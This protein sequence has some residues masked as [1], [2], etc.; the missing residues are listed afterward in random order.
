MGRYV[1]FSPVPVLVSGKKIDQAHEYRLD[2]KAEIQS[3]LL[4]DIP[5][6]QNSAR[7]AVGA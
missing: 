6:A 4:T 1:L 2:M 7:H 3:V 5:S